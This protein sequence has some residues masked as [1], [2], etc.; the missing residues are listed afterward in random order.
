MCLLP[1]THTL[2]LKGL[3]FFKCHSGLL[4]LPW[5]EFDV[6]CFSSM[7][8]VS[9]NGT[10]PCST[11][12]RDPK[13]KSP[14][15]RNSYFSCP[16]GIG[17]R[18]SFGSSSSS[19]DRCCEHNMPAARVLVSAA[20]AVAH[21]YDPY[22]KRHDPLTTA[23]TTLS[24]LQFLYF[25]RFFFCRFCVDTQLSSAYSYSVRLPSVGYLVHRRFQLVCWLPQTR[26]LSAK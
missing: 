13:W 14:A 12:W 10:S 19:S 1:H 6:F 16:F 3:L 2:Y 21:S 8:I 25:S 15:P 7:I 20:P 4:F 5:L 26:F 9:G 24:Q 17:L 11:S 22:F 23:P 18:L